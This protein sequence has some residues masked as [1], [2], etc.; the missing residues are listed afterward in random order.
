MDIYRMTMI[1]ALTIAVV[2]APALA[3]AY[4]GGGAWSSSG[5]Q[6]SGGGVSVGPG[7]AQTFS[8]GGNFMYSMT[9]VSPDDAARLQSEGVRVVMAPAGR[10]VHVTAQSGGPLNVDT[11]S[12]LPNTIVFGPG[13]LA[14]VGV[15]TGPGAGASASAGAIAGPGGAA[16]MYSFTGAAGDAYL[17]TQQSGGNMDRVLVV[18]Q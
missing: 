3:Q 5:G 2:S 14:G 16:Q 13:G 6:V 9:S 7:G 17:I 10:S 12:P 8:L 1:I 11:K 4:A 15:Y 18:F